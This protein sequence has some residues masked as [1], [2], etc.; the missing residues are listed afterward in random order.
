M[1]PRSYRRLNTLKSSSAVYLKSVKRYSGRTNAES[2]PSTMST[3]RALI[4]T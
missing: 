4:R 3:S 1:E 2:R